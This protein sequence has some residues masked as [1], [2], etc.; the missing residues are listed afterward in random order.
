MTG[1]IRVLSHIHSALVD[2]AQDVDGL[3]IAPPEAV[4]ARGEARRRRQVVG[5]VAV[6]VVGAAVTGAVALPVLHGDRGASGGS[7]GVAAPPSASGCVS[8]SPSGPPPQKFPNDA[9]SAE[10]ADSRMATVYLKL[11]ISADQKGAVDTK[12]RSLA[13]VTSVELVDRA[14]TWQNFVRTFCYAPDLVAVTKPE[15]LPE[16]FVITLAAPGDFA[17]VSRTI[18]ILPGVDAVVRRPQ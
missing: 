3:R 11:T 8:P 7:L 2:L 17:D 13:G 16:S 10:L 14:H 1:R 6:V 18:A 15:Q 5:A 4:R 9:V 12:L